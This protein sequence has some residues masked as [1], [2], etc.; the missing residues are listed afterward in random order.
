M[1]RSVRVAIPSYNY[2]RYLPICA[3]TVLA[4]E[5][6]DVRVLIIDDASSDGSQQVAADLAKSDERIEVRCHGANMGHLRTYNEGL[7]WGV[8]ADYVVLISPDDALTP[9]A[10]ARACDLFEAHPGVGFV[11]GKPC[12]FRGEGPLP[13][14]ELGPAEWKVW[15]GMEWFRTR[16]EAGGNCISSPEAVIRSSVLKK[17]GNFREDLPHSG[18]FELWMRLALHGDVGFIEGPNQAYYRNHDLGMHNVKF[19]TAL[20]DLTEM[21]KAFDV[22]FTNHRDQIP[23]CERL[24]EINR[25][26]VADRALAA[27]GK[28]LDR[29]PA[30]AAAVG[31][32]EEFAIATCGDIRELP[33][34]RKLMARKIS[35]AFQKIRASRSTDLR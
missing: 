15:P 17:A 33:E 6:V 2:A 25:R 22:L 27:A 21:K 29:D 10:L 12:Y 19:G 24:M 35:P 11:Y 3:G 4:Q 28:L 8:A 18:D 16:C 13:E 31:A 26:K 9:N 14:A 30:D 32:L 34:W 7:E 5:G 20:A 23:D 1:S